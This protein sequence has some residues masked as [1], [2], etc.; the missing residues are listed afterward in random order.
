MLVPAAPD[1]IVSCRPLASVQEKNHYCAPNGW[2]LNRRQFTVTHKF[3]Q[4]TNV[5]P[6]SDAVTET[7]DF[8]DC[9]GRETNGKCVPGQAGT[10]ACMK[11]TN[12]LAEKELLNSTW[13]S[14]GLS[15]EPDIRTDRLK[16]H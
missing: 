14:R 3:T 1:L 11:E 4:A 13:W 5:L 10:C 8:E 9:S 16:E 15:R 6:F 12:R 7:Q 2:D